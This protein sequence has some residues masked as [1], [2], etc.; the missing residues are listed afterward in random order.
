[1]VGC[2]GPRSGSPKHGLLVLQGPQNAQNILVETNAEGT[3]FKKAALPS[4]E[5][6]RRCKK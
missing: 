1:M 3:Q 4:A 2:S 5:G 6:N